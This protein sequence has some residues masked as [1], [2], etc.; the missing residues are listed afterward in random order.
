MSVLDQLT[1]SIFDRLLTHPLVL[2]KVVDDFVCIVVNN[3]NTLEKE[4]SFWLSSTK[5]HRTFL[6]F[7]FLCFYLIDFSNSLTDTCTQYKAMWLRFVKASLFLQ[8]HDLTLLFR[9]WR[10]CFSKNIGP[11]VSLLFVISFIARLDSYF[12]CD[13]KKSQFDYM[14]KYNVE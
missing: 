4:D 2:N 10:L 9:Q 13:R 1:T 3:T 14:S 5:L 12:F 7:H 11:F 6:Y 8:V